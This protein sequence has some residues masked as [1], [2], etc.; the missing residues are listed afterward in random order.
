[1]LVN[2]YAK[3]IGWLYFK[4][5]FVI[6]IALVFFYVGIDILTNLKDMPTSANLKL[7]YFSLTSLTA[8]NYVLPLSLIFALIVSK[9]NMIRSNELVSFYALGISK[10]S[11]IKPPFIIALVITLIYIGL[12]FTPFAYSYEF[13]RNLMKTSQISR[14]SSD[15]FLKF[16][17]K[18]IYIKELNPVT[19]SVQDIRIFDVADGKLKSATFSNEAKFDGNK[20]IL[21]DVNVTTMPESIKLGSKGLDIKRYDT[22]ETLG[23]FKPKT[24]ENA[25]QSNSSIS[26]L[27]A[28]DFIFAFEKEGVGLNAAKATLYNLLFSPFFAPL[29][30]FI[31]S[32]FL[33]VT[34]R[35]F[36]LALTSFVFIIVTLCVWGALFVLMKFAHN[37]VILPE[38][39]V[40]LPIICIFGFASYLYFK[41]R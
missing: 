33:P 24:I 34:G 3:Y 1:M 38:L 21:K 35:F 25:Y 26:I 13:Q 17:G 19:S 4:S 41:H 16:E 27:D 7:L 18:F 37:G 14:I 2:L 11:L 10:N 20:W 28:I 36:N 5:F 12:N 29:M 31:I 6:F 8:V 40:L 32:Y 15:I 30:V 22:L 39:G 23:G 9:F